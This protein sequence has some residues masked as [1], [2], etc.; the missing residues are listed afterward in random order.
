MRNLERML[1]EERMVSAQ[2]DQ[3]LSI[4]YRKLPISLIH[5]LENADG[6]ESVSSNQSFDNKEQIHM[7]KTIENLKNTIHQHESVI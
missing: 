7:S 6:T 2:K 5:A 4:R 3:E 1:E